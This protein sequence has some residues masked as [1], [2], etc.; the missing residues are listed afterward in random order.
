MIVFQCKD[1]HKGETIMFATYAALLLVAA[2][3]GIY[4]LTT[5]GSYQ[6]RF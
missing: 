6:G 5:G 3:V 2:I 1:K 4:L